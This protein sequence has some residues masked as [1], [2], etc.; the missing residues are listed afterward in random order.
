VN[1]ER[2]ELKKP[3]TKRVARFANDADLPRMTAEAMINVNP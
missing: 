2:I 1:A 3:S